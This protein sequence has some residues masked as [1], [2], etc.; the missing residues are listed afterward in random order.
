MALSGPK[1]SY[2]GIKMSVSQEFEKETHARTCLRQQNQ[3]MLTRTSLE[4]KPTPIYGARDNSIFSK[5]HVSR[6]FNVNL[7]F[8][9]ITVLHSLWFGF[10][11][12]HRR[13][14]LGLQLYV[15]R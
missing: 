5:N 8:I 7:D 4:G 12:L 3:A 14:H 13:I 11:V 9:G 1:S 6:Q 2:D 15:L 10:R